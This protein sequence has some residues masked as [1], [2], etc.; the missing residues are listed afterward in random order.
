LGQDYD[1]FEVIAVMDGADVKCERILKKYKDKRLKYITIKHGGACKARN[2]GAKLATGEYV[3]FFS[4]DFEMVPGG[5]RRWADELKD[6]PDFIY[7]GYRWK[8]ENQVMQEA[9]QTEDL[10][11]YS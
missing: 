4:S 3:S 6:N 8:N 5:L 1:S 10:T 7:S 11:R 2:E 9:Y